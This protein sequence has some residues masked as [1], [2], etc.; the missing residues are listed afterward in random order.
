MKH[1][2]RSGK[3]RSFL[4]FKYIV[5]VMA[6][7][8]HRK[9]NKVLLSLIVIAN[10]MNPLGKLGS[11]I[12]YLTKEEQKYVIDNIQPEGV[13]ISKLT[14]S[15]ESFKQNVLTLDFIHGLFD[16]DGN[17]TVSLSNSSSSKLVEKSRISVNISFTIVQ[18]VH[19]I[20]LLDELKMYFNNK[21]NIYK[22]SNNCSI[23][24]VGSRSDLM[25]AI[26]PKMAGKESRESLKDCS[27]EA[28]NLPLMKYNKIFYISKILEYSF[29][30]L[31]N[32]KEILNEIVRLSYYV[33]KN[34]DNLTLEEY[35]KEMD[36]KF[37]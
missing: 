26:I 37:I 17:I 35:V 24:K 36:K 9:D 12:R 30:D 2:L 22:L 10:N 18:D 6:T 27:I 33:I 15:I 7:K 23:Y 20:S 34:A 13:D 29:V 5:E 19:N 8:A 11:N 25:S 14:E 31:R 21:G 4:Y 1:Q 16:G 28:L 32:N 3:L